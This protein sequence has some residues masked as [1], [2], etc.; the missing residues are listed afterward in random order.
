MS[1]DIAFLV[2]FCII[3]GLVLIIH[4]KKVGREGPIF[5][6]RTQIGIKII[7]KI[8]K[9]YPKTLNALSYVII[10][11]GYILTAMMIWLLVQIVWLFSK[12]E[13]VQMIKIPPLM[14]FIPYLPQLFKVEWL[15]PLYFTY[16]IVITAVVAIAHEG[17][18]GIY[19]R[20]YNIKIK[21]TG[22]GFLGPIMTFFVEPDEKAMKKAKPRHQMAMLGAGVFGNLLCAAVF[23]FI[24]LLFFSLAYTPSGALFNTYSY[25]TIPITAAANASVGTDKI[26]LD[27]MNLTQITFENHSFY[28]WENHLQTYKDYETGLINIYQDMPALHAKLNGAISA[29][30]DVQVK[31]S[32][33]LGTQLEKYK[34]GDSVTIETK[35][36][37]G[38]TEYKLVLG[39]DYDKKGRAVLGIGVLMPKTTGVK[40]F[41]YKI[42]NSFRDPTVY[43][44]PKADSNLIEFVYYL[45]WWIVLVSFGMALFNILPLAIADG[46]RFWYLNVLA[47]TGSK[48]IAEKTYKATTG[49]ILAIFILLMV[50]WAIGM[51]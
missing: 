16:W 26:I 8:S 50:F 32:T 17:F 25:S 18:H 51:F 7:D 36:K 42:M 29:I 47:L 23:F 19:A 13:Y 45:V 11:A 34:P 31:T 39:E 4:R 40:G 20:L 41:L 3:A 43:Y 14:P 35:N 48:K 27:G 37:T 15:P 22:F 10:F 46:G 28:I 24:L 38:T 6:Y 49:I 9:K 12:P 30:N 1:Y 2:L 44:E 33:E 21:S 5:L